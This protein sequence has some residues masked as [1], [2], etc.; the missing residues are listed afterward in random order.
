MTTATFVPVE[1]YLANTYEPDREYVDGALVE[2][3]V[4]EY[5]HS[6]LENLIGVYLHALRKHV[7]LRAFTEQRLRMT[8]NSGGVRYRIPDVCVMAPGH[9]R[10][11][12]LA[13]PPVLVV[14]ILSPDDRMN[15]VLR[16]IGEYIRFGVGAIW[17]VDP[18]ERKLFTA[19]GSGLHEVNDRVGRFSCAGVGLEVDFDSIFAE[20]DE[21]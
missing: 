17:I 15:D 8:D 10:T 13:E 21:A 20:L 6:V 5:D 7:P 3:N 1:E 16:K 14:E 19:D 4:G 12:V 11:P 9:A 18:V 2:R